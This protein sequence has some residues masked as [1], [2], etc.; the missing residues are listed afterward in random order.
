MLE[1]YYHQEVLWSSNTWHN[2]IDKSFFNFSYF[3]KWRYFIDILSSETAFFYFFVRHNQTLLTHHHTFFIIRE[4]FTY[5]PWTFTPFEK[6]YLNFKTSHFRVSI[7]HKVSI[8]VFCSNFLL[9]PVIIPKTT[10][11]FLGK[12]LLGFRCWS[13]FNGI[14]KNTYA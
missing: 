12:K 5:N 9:N 10:H 1:L 11:F 8:S 14:C 7:F 6:M 13:E 3:F 4:N 2:L